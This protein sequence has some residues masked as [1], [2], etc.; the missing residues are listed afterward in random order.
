MAKAKGLL[1]LDKALLKD[2]VDKIN[3][4][5]QRVDDAL[6]VTARMTAEFMAEVVLEKAL[7][8]VPVKTGELKSSGRVFG[9]RFRGNMMSARV[10]FTA[11]H[12]KVMDTGWDVDVIKPVNS[13]SLAINLGAGNVDSGVVRRGLSR[14]P[15]N[16][17]RLD[18]RIAAENASGIIRRPFVKTR[19]VG[20]GK[21][22]PNRYLT[23]ALEKAANDPKKFVTEARRQIARELKENR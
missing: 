14:L 5:I 1:S 3:K 6:Y 18:A 13:R 21:K 10:E 19:P 11:G 2:S 23:D 15:R 9:P 7:K 4:S 17:D 22:G 16:S 20:T 12:A 8:R